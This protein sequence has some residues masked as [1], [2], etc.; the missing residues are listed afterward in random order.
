MH[1]EKLAAFGDGWL[2]MCAEAIRIQQNAALSMW[3]PSMWNPWRTQS[4]NI[5]RLFSPGALTRD[6]LAVTCMGIAPVRR[7]AVAN[8]KRLGK[9]KR[10]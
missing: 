7:K 1:T 8:A 3:N 6:V 5:P 9:V 10:R 4:S 2:A